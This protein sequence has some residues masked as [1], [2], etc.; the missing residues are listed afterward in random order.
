MPVCNSSFSE[1]VFSTAVEAHLIQSNSSDIFSKPN[2]QMHLQSFKMLWIYWA[3]CAHWAVLVFWF[4]SQLRLYHT[5]RVVTSRHAK[6][7]SV[8]DGTPENPLLLLLSDI[9]LFNKYP[10]LDGTGTF[11]TSLQE[12]TTGPLSQINPVTPLCPVS[13]RFNLVLSFHLCLGLPNG[14]F[15]SGFQTKVLY[16]FQIFPMHAACLVHLIF[17]QY[18]WCI[19]YRVQIVK[20]SLWKF[21]V[22]TI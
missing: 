3:V 9:Q 8:V 7:A 5:M 13:S 21:L 14:L 22:S 16:V 15:P 19:W 6:I 1:H 17:L 18:I 4:S 11:I 20:I 12:H 2:S 10:H